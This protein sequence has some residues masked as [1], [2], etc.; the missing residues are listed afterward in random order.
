MSR[1]ADLFENLV[2]TRKPSASIAYAW[3]TGLIEFGA[4]SRGIP[5]GALPLA[6]GNPAKLREIVCVRARRS[7]AGEPLVPGVPEAKTDKAAVDALITWR[8]WAFKNSEKDGVKIVRC[9]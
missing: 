3:A 4:H 6:K 2:T 1:Q 5:R 7:Y 8:E 9:F